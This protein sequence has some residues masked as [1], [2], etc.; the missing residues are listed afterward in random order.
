MLEQIK[1]T[2]FVTQTGSWLS[3]H[4]ALCKISKSLY[5][6]TDRHVARNSQWGG[7]LW[8]SGGGAPSAQKFRIFFAELT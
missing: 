6:F 7:L 2:I 5:L 1:A 3:K 8:G 4:L